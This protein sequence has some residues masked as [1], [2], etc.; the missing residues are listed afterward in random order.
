MGINLQHEDID[1]LANAQRK[2]AKKS[3]LLYSGG[4][5][6]TVLLY[7]LRPALALFI[8]YGQRH[9]KEYDKA[10]EHC[11]KLGI[12]LLDRKIELA[13]GVA[14]EGEAFICPIRNLVF[15]SLAANLAIE[16]DCNQ[17]TI[18]CNLTDK[19]LFPDCRPG[20]LEYV[21]HAIIS[22]GYDLRVEAPFI[23]V[24]K[25]EIGERAKKIGITP[26]SVWSCYKGGDEP[27]G[28]CVACEENPFFSGKKIS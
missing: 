27:C 17:I 6:S 24:D 10:K 18:G 4:L 5:D 8:S 25:A 3:L 26:E 21:R 15:L 9:Q 16:H 14:D 23:M 11:E 2:P 28:E 13:G 12:T 1:M 20:F 19:E 22:S 7:E